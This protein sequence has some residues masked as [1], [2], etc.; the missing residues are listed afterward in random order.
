MVEAAAQDLGCDLAAL[1]ALLQVE[2]WGAGVSGFGRK[3]RVTARFE[4]HHFS[5]YTNGRFDNSH[6]HISS[7][8]WNWGL[9]PAGPDGVFI[10]IDEA[11]SLDR[12]A[13]LKSTS[14]GLGQIMGFNH[15]LCGFETPEAMVQ[16]FRRSEKDQLDALV[17]FLRATDL[18]GKLR[19]H[20]W[21]GFARGYNGPGFK[22][23]KYDEKLRKA[24]RSFSGKHSFVVLRRGSAGLGVQRLQRALR[25]H[26][27]ENITS[28]GA[29]G[30]MTEAAVKSFQAKRGLEVDGI[31][32]AKTWEALQV[33]PKKEVTT[34]PTPV[35]AIPGLTKITAAIT[36]FFTAI[37][38]AF[39][40]SA[41]EILPQPI[42]AAA[43]IA[44]ASWTL[45]QMREELF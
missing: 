19:A 23:T 12:T 2:V 15:H 29:F 24:Y 28:D 20:D 17:K 16:A 25:T 30:E 18:D 27:Y 44:I 4:P 38:E 43:V 21:E 39:G 45:W 14:W 1:Q 5:A 35:E 10:Q 7:K 8:V 42:I 31:V 22:K 11:A 33:S 26:G 34:K 9:Y 40:V 37:S 6:Q 13:A 3:G 41:F 32:G 36:G